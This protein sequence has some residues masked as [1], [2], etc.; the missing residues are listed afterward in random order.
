MTIPTEPSVVEPTPTPEVTSDDRMW[1]LL[2]F[3]FTPI[4]P[5]VMMLMEDKKARPFIKYHAVPALILGIAVAVVATLLALIPFVGCI[6]PF[7]WIIPIVYGIKAYKGVYTDVP[8]IT[9]FSQDQ[10]WS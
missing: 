10:G 9:K 7:L 3:I 2:S 5:V 1:V 6:T 8:V 4:I